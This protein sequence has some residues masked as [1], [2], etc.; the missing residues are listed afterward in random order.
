MPRGDT[1]GTAICGRLLEAFIRKHASFDSLGVFSIDVVK[2]KPLYRDVPAFRTH[3]GTLRDYLHEFTCLEYVPRTEWAGAKVID[4]SVACNA[5][6]PEDHNSTE[7]T[8][9]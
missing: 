6:I 1:Q 4:H 9:P 7:T 3:L 8:T 2:L 5:C